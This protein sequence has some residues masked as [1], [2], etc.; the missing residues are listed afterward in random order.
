MMND[1][2]I[3][4]EDHLTASFALEFIDLLLLENKPDEQRIN[5]LLSTAIDKSENEFDLLQLCAITSLRIGNRVIAKKLLKQLVNEDYNKIVNAQLL[6]CIYVQERNYPEYEVLGMRVADRYLFPMPSKDEN[7][8]NELKERFEMSQRKLLKEKFRY[9]LKTALSFYSQ[10]MNRKISVFDLNEEYEEDFFADNERGRRLRHSKAEKV[11]T[12]ETRRNYYLDRLRTISLPVAYTDAADDMLQKI[13]SVSMFNSENLRKKAIETTVD[14]LRKHKDQINSCQDK[15]KTDAFTIREYDVLQ[16]I[17]ISVLLR[18][19]MDV[20]YRSVCAT[21][22]SVSGTGLMSLDGNL[23]K[24]C[25]MLNIS[26]PEIET[27]NAGLTREKA[28]DIPHLSVNLFGSEAYIAHKETELLA[29]MADYVKKLLGSIRVS[30]KVI[31]LYRDCLD[32]SF[33]NYFNNS[34]FDEYPTLYANS[35]AVMQHFNDKYDFIFAVDGIVYMYRW[36]VM[37]KV[38]Y[39]EISLQKDELNL[40]GTKIKSSDVDLNGL[41][42]VIRNIRGKYIFDKLQR[43]EYVGTEAN[44]KMLNK[45]FKSTSCDSIEGA[46]MVYAMPEKNL[47]DSL[48]IVLEGSDWSNCLLQFIYDTKNMLVLEYRIVEFEKLESK[49]KTQLEQ[50]NGVIRLGY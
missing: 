21:I 47:L 43:H 29:E 31:L 9:T 38:P 1:F 16:S 44:V 34:V 22:D 3:L 19:T 8:V 45:W 30:D 4:R 50:K 18:D 12:D 6:S 20:L 36:Q 28:D 23:F 14:S 26:M 7:N 17:G 2:N 35:I 46:E 15:V 37:K 10:R 48:G 33:D 11:L 25:D 49:F 24:L 13:L 5:K 41:F 40:W 39:E 32:M 27:G 42:G